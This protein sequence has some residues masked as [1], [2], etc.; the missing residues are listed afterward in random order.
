MAVNAGNGNGKS[1]IDESDRRPIPDSRF[2]IPE[3]SA[4]SAQPGTAYILIRTATPAVNPA[5]L[6]SIDSPSI[7]RMSLSPRV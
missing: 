7:S 5:F 1:G 2:P 3:F 6:A 4:P